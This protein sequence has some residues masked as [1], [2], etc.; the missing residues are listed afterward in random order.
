MGIKDLKK[1]LKKLA[2]GAFHQ[3][4]P[5]K[6][7]VFIDE[8]FPRMF[9]Y[10][11]IDD[12]IECVELLRML[13]AE[14]LSFFDTELAKVLVVIGDDVRYVPRQ[15]S[16]EQAKRRASRNVYPK[17]MTLMPCVL[18]RADGE[19]ELTEGGIR[20]EV[21]N[22]TQATV[23]PNLL[24]A[25]SHMRQAFIQQLF[26]Y[27]AHIMDLPV[28]SRI[29]FDM[30]FNNIIFRHGRNVSVVPQE[31]LYN[32]IGEG[33][34]KAVWWYLALRDALQLPADMNYMIKTKDL[35]AVPLMAFHCGDV[36]TR[37]NGL[38]YV[39]DNTS[40]YMNV[41][42]LFQTLESSGWNL[43]M[44][45]GASLLS[46]SD[47]TDKKNAT[48]QIGLQTMW[49]CFEEYKT[50]FKFA[51]R[52]T[53]LNRYT[54]CQ[55]KALRAWFEVMVKLNFVCRRKRGAGHD[56]FEVTWE[57]L[58]QDVFMLRVKS[59]N[60]PGS[61]LFNL[62]LREFVWLWVYWASLGS[63]ISDLI[64]H[65]GAINPVSSEATY[66]ELKGPKLDKCA[67]CMAHGDAAPATMATAS[68]RKALG[69]TTPALP[70]SSSTAAQASFTATGTLAAEIPD[71][72]LTAHGEP[73]SIEHV[74]AIQKGFDGITGHS[75]S[76]LRYYLKV[77]AKAAESLRAFRFSALHYA[78]TCRRSAP[79]GSAVSSASGFTYSRMSEAAQLDADVQE[80][81]KRA[82]EYDKGEKED[83]RVAVGQRGFR[84]QSPTFTVDAAMRDE[85]NADGQGA[86][87]TA[88]SEPLL[89]S[90]T[91]SSWMIVDVPD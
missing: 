85:G 13:S 71:N 87:A 14:Y 30:G 52:N 19:W 1:H 79:A 44:L 50:G 80:L 78:E 55:Y 23:C 24:V 65:R 47:Y 69:A 20:D 42:T 16:A 68:D 70:S 88:T 76:T 59:P 7:A 43:Q 4:A 10:A 66:L 22:T 84:A 56:P 72:V 11:S 34:I 77:M 32:K 25:S 39:T 37:P 82:M 12:E 57:S 28:Q 64:L 67:V 27:M 58:A 63:K 62:G 53:P 86:A 5:P 61:K 48:D 51:S 29:F 75:R 3:C 9:K 36:V 40:G 81:I 73:G 46:G 83:K 2:P 17:T 60:P 74:S 8:T 49:D 41:G 89:P 90:A 33:E 35:D 26:L 6:C 54:M 18:Q 91:P 15:K 45:I 38:L 31:M 21:R